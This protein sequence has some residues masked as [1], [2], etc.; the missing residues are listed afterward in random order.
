MATVLYVALVAVKAE[1]FEM[2]VEQPHGSFCYVLLFSG[3]SGCH[4]S[5][6]SHLKRVFKRSAIVIYY[7]NVLPHCTSSCSA[8]FSL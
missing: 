4:S 1:T 3:L 6:P 2:V 7:I 5:S 8:Y